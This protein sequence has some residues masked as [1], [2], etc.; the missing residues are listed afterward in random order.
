MIRKIPL[1]AAILWIFSF[2]GNALAADYERSE[3]IVS[4]AELSTLL[5]KDTVK[6]VDARK[7]D[8]YQVGHIPGA[9]SLPRKKT[10]FK[11]RGT[12]GFMVPLKAMEKIFSD[13]GIKPTDTLIFYDDQMKPTVTRLFWTPHVLGHQKARVL[14][15]GMALWVKEARPVS[16]EIPSV[17]TSD[18]K[19]KPDWSVLADSAYVFSKLNKPE[20]T[21]IDTR[22]PKEW[23][24]L[25]ASRKVKRAGRIPGAKLVDWSWH[26]TKKDGVTTLKTAAELK[27]MFARTGATKEKEIISYCRTGMR[28]SHS[29]WV[30]KLL[31][32]P[33]VRNFDGSM[34]RMGK[35]HGASP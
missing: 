7:L 30:L 8:K 29:Y 35:S 16:K 5:D 13:R 32:Y 10:Q 24:G 28:S 6:I 27:R 22:S 14:N 9:I 3:F 17:I 12:S 31:G 34:N 26:V 2:A 19:A 33:N 20:I 1:T 25:K 18:Y 4:T 21:L 15:G 11:W 23:S